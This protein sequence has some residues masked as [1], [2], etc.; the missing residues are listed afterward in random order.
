LIE[1]ILKRKTVY[2]AGPMTGYERYNA[3]AFNAAAADLR[4]RGYRVINPV[5]LDI[6]V[7]FDPST[8]SPEDFDLPAAIRRDVNALIEC[9]AI[10]MLPGHETSKGATAERHVAIWRGLEVLSYPSMVPLDKVDAVEDDFVSIPPQSVKRFRLT[11]VQID[12]TNFGIGENQPA[13]YCWEK[14]A[15]AADEA[16]QLTEDGPAEWSEAIAEVESQPIE[17][18][19]TWSTDWNGVIDG[20]DDSGFQPIGHEK[21]AEAVTGSPCGK[22]WIPEPDDESIGQEIVGRLER[23]TNAI[24]DGDTV[25][26]ERG[27]KQSHLSARFDCIPPEVLRLLAQ[28]LGYGCARYGKENWRNIDQEDNLAH[29]MNHINEYRMN[30]P[31]LVN[32]MARITFALSQAVEKGDQPTTYIHPDAGK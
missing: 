11:P 1:E 27:G 25:T 3:D 8:D 24:K 6:E 9:D 22:L 21:L 2:I 23:F 4:Q 20:G 29:A 30:E 19:S 14:S 13:P 5:E 18:V 17:I 16:K 15:I 10:V 12:P 32:A 31:H 28:C 26:N 7:G